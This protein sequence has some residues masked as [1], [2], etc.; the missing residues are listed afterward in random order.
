MEN[1]L[2]QY[3]VE[4]VSFECIDEKRFR[5]DQNGPMIHLKR[6]FSKNFKKKKPEKIGK[7]FSQNF[8]ENFS[9]PFFLLFYQHK[10]TQRQQ[11]NKFCIK[12]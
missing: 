8:P 6:R 3:S 9:A 7:K 10:N 12:F 1:S 2:N 11:I 4:L 5:F